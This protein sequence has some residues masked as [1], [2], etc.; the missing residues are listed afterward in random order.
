[1]KLGTEKQWKG[2]KDK[3]EGM[4]KEH[5]EFGCI[6]FTEYHL[7]PAIEVM[8]KIEPTEQVPDGILFNF[9]RY[10]SDKRLTNI[11]R[12][13]FIGVSLTNLSDSRLFITEGVS[14][15]LSLK[16]QYPH[17]NV[18][19]KT[20][21]NLSALQLAVIKANFRT[22][23]IV[24]D[25][26]ATGLSKGYDLVRSLK[27]VRLETELVLSINKDITLDI[28]CGEIPEKLKSLAI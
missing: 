1:M 4:L 9:V 22:V 15:F 11:D 7:N 19:G 13:G 28:F 12:L 14:D 21:L 16:I 6:E 18:W 10:F 26:D 23:V 3:W 25:N 24:T 5:P 2:L 17:L 8:E 27:R 20:K